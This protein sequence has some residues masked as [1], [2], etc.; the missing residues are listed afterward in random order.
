MSRLPARLL[1][2]AITGL[3][4]GCPSVLPGPDDHAGAVSLRCPR[5]SGP[6]LALPLPSVEAGSSA[7]RSKSLVRL[8]WN[9]IGW[10]G[11]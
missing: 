6:A 4:S 1:S 10:E 5:A 7:Q 9:A 8:L 2:K 3:G 11:Q